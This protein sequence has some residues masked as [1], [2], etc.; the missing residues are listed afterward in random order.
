M[1][2]NKEDLKTWDV[3]LKI[4]DKL[5]DPVQQIQ[6]PKIMLELTGPEIGE[7]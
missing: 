3:K 1:D 7:K 5:K 2:F 6:V 4:T